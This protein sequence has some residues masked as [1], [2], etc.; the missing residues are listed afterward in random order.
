MNE[1][2]KKNI[3]IIDFGF[4]TKATNYIGNKGRVEGTLSYMAP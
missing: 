3:K 1:A 4:A 2:K